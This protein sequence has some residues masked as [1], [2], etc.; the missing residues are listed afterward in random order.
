MRAS[1]YVVKL[2]QKGTG[3]EVIMSMQE[4]SDWLLATHPE[5]F[6]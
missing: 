4:Y 5:K 3:K 6:N 2:R 1:R